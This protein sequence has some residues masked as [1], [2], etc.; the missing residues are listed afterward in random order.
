ME[1]LAVPSAGKRAP[2]TPVVQEGIFRPAEVSRTEYALA[3]IRI[4]RIV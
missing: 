2:G 3:A 1:P 4:A